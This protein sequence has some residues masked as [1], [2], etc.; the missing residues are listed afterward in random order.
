MLGSQAFLFTLLLSWI[1]GSPSAE[2]NT[3]LLLLEF[4]RNLPKSIFKVKLYC[5]P[6]SYV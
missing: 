3:V 2:R 5:L 4:F 1:A 6:W